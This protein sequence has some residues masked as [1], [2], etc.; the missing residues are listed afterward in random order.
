M[1][2]E[3][4][5]V[6]LQQLTFKIEHLLNTFFP[7]RS[8]TKPVKITRRKQNTTV[9]WN[10]YPKDGTQRDRLFQALSNTIDENLE[11]LKGEIIRNKLTNGRILDRG[12]Q[13]FEIIRGISWEIYLYEPETF[14]FIRLLNEMSLT[15]LSKN[16][17][18]ID[19]DIVEESAWFSEKSL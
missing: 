5:P 16:W 12:V 4:L 13:E 11:E 18:S 10:I 9:T 6:V 17:I 3:I 15:P 14:I 1:K 2:V 19:I 8:L 7:E